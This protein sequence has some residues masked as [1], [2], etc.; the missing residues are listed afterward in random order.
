VSRRVLAATAGLSLGYVNDVLAGTQAPTLEVY[1]RLAAALSADLSLRLYP[2]TGP[3]IHD[4][5]QA[6]MLE[7]VLRVRHPRWDPYPEAFVTRPIQGW[8]DLALHEPR[9]RVLVATELQSEIR[10][11]EQLVRW[12]AAKA[13]ALPSW[14]GFVHL[15]DAPRISQLM[16]VRRTRATRQAA[17]EF[18]RQLRAAFPAHPDDALAAL[19]GTAPWPGA[20][21]AWMVVDAKGARLVPGR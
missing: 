12:Q 5:W 1:H 13:Q 20:A 4:R 19:T 16:I 10:R 9:E 21:L 2:N 8:V 3:H 17:A 14:E 6:P 7:E 15:G 18:H 11:F